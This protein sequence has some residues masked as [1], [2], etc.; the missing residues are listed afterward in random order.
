MRT[1][2]GR[3][4][5]RDPQRK[6]SRPFPFRLTCMHV[7]AA[8]LAALTGCKRSMDLVGRESPGDG[9]LNNADFLTG[10]REMTTEPSLMAIWPFPFLTAVERFT[11]I[12]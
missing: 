11:A 4:P 9:L 8:G 10:E 5:R 6:L 1:A 12:A 3:R 7:A 2:I